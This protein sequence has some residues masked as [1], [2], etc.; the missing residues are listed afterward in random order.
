MPTGT[1]MM[2]SGIASELVS[3]DG[4]WLFCDGSAVSRTTYS[5]LFRVI[6]TNYGSGNGIDT[7]NLPDLRSRF[8]WGSNDSSNIRLDILVRRHQLD[9]E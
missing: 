1:I 9:N 3:T 6:G 4:R 5:A 7:F 8:P 2:Y